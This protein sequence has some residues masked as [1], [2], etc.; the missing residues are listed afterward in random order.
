MSVRQGDK[1]VGGELGKVGLVGPG[2]V[3]GF[4]GGMLANAG[5][6]L[7]FLLRSTYEFVSSEGL[8]NDE[9]STGV[10]CCFLNFF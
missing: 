1:R 9:V 5:V 8:P 7:H 2:A 3:G 4:Y 6:D 10:S